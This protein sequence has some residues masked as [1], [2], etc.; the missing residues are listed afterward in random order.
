MSNVRTFI[1]SGTDQKNVN[2]ERL[3]E[4]A[5][6]ILTACESGSIVSLIAI[7]VKVDDGCLAFSGS[8]VEGFTNLKA[9]G[10]AAWM[11]NQIQQGNY[12]E[13]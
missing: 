4:I 9:Q 11:L 13:P 12:N 7:G 5:K 3:I 8:A 1:G 6:S 2:K 10:C